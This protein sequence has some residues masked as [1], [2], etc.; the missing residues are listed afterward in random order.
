MEMNEHLS[1]FSG[2]DRVIH[3][4]GPAFEGGHLEERDVRVAHVV[5]RDPRVHP[6][7]VVLRQT[8]LDVGH[9][10]GAHAFIRYHVHAL[11]LANSCGA[12]VIYH[13]SHILGG[14]YVIVVAVVLVVTW[15]KGT[16]DYSSNSHQAPKA[17]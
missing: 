7:R 11:L 6:H 5:E 3:D 15:I 1:H 12:A 16:V 10:L 13:I 9:D 2:I 14:I 4:H 17:Y 8:G